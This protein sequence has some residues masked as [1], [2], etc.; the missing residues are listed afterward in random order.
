[1][2][3]NG[4]SRWIDQ[5]R[6]CREVTLTSPVVYD[7][8]EIR[9]I[10]IREPVVLDLEEIP[11]TAFEKPIFFLREVLAACSGL[12]VTAIRCLTLPDFTACARA[13]SDMGFQLGQAY[14]LLAQQ[15]GSLLET[16]PTGSPSS[17]SDSTSGNP[18]SG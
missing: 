15:M 14:G 11:A 4:E 17:N 13:L 12:S 3:A 10:R 8:R 1:M 18:N 7:G 2:A 9:T 16:G 6:Q 5:H